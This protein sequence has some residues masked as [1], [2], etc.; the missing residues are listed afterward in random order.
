MLRLPIS[1][2]L[3]R[4]AAGSSAAI[5]V[6]LLLLMVRPAFAQDKAVVFGSV[7]NQ[8]GEPL[9]S[10]NVSI[11]GKP[12]GV[13]TDKLGTYSLHVPAGEKLTLIF[14]FVGYKRI[15]VNIELKPYERKQI[16]QV[17]QVE[18]FDI[19]P[20]YIIGEKVDRGAITRIEPKNAD[21]IP[22]LS[23]GGIE[24][25]VKKTS[26]GVYSNN[27]LSSQYSVRG[28]NYDENLVYVNEVEIYRP[29]LT[30]SGQ[31]EGLSFVNSDLAEN[32][33]F[34]S[35]GFD[36]KYGDK[37][38]SVLD[39][40]YRRPKKFGGGLDLSLLG[41]SGY[42]EGAAAKGR[43]TYLVGAR[44]KSN[45][46]FLNQLETKGQY[47]PSFTDVQTC[48][49][50]VISEKW[51]ISFLGNYAR[52]KYL[53]VPESR[54]T[55]FGTVQESY[56]L[57]IYF[58]GQELDR[59]STLFGA[60]TATYSP[61]QHTRLKLITSA[62]NT[63]EREAY[64]ING[65]YW[66]GKL[67]T[68]F[69]KDDFGE[70]TENLGVG[71]HFSHARNELD[72]TVFT[73]EHKGSHQKKKNFWQWGIKYQ[74]EMIYD[75]LKEWQMID[76]SGYTLVRPPDSVGYTNPG[77][78]P[79]N[80]LEL[81]EVVRTDIDLFTHRFSAFLQDTWTW[82]IDSARLTF[83][84]GVRGS[85][86]TY[87]Q[88]WVISPRIT[89]T[90]KPNWKQDVVFRL[91]AGVYN[92]PPFYKELRGFNGALNPELRAQQSYHFVFGTDWNFM[93]WNRPFKFMSEV[94]YKYLDNIIP[95]EI[96]NVRIRYFATNN[97]R[98]YATGI[99]LKIHGEF[100]QDIESWLGLSLMQTREDIQD[101]YYYTYY[102]AEG[103]KIIPGYTADQ[104]V[105]D[106][107]RTEPGFVPRP[108]DQ[109]LTV[110]LFFQD[111]L[112]RFPT[113]KMHL[114]FL[115]STGLAFGPPSHERYKDTLRAPAY[116]RVDIGFSKLLIGESSVF[117][118]KNPLR[119]LKSVWI[120]AE[121]FNLLG[122]LNTVSYLWVKDV[123]NRQ[124]AVPNEL[125]RRMINVKLHVK[126]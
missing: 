72:A 11:L 95:Y 40:T 120:S 41:V 70:V 104:V 31:Q 16:D 91:S 80:P 51:E 99:D 89:A 113:Y 125:T 88:Q 4:R 102:N 62:F 119:H 77:L 115:Y 122:R 69:G 75:R 98:G 32:V 38:S 35:G 114:N 9:E 71:T 21:I 103:E 94:Y 65:Q 46:Y 13:L 6:L 111:Y 110:N 117:R 85:W 67:E 25:L 55:E 126:F 54:E 1:K 48:L 66:I 116:F 60:L 118:K 10:V 42:L 5:C 63:S 3:L 8:K 36:A 17:M 50:Y 19:D 12:L 26:L 57:K 53:V 112:P 64:D 58:E 43:F 79:W 14:S 82:Y 73:L 23:G 45:S 24:E 81:Q 2:E 61:N 83:A 121:V 106:S 123:N 100:V 34:S 84:A 86:W 29:F 87:N 27:E 107:V 30:R 28:G 105:A 90:L 108:T 59:I 124:Y 15:P 96:D 52:N 20:T 44:Q 97:A 76:S 22:S 37:M 101:D 92:Q 7:K 56:R 74:G 68:D 39:I 33:L 93:A 47:K 49:S 78:Q 18:V 109:L